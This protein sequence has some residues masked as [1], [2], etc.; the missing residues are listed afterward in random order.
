MFYLRR[1]NS[2]NKLTDWKPFTTVPSNRTYRR[3]VQIKLTKA[4]VVQEE[5]SPHWDHSLPVHTPF[6]FQCDTPVQPRPI[7]VSQLRTR[8]T[9]PVSG[10]AIQNSGVARGCENHLSHEPIR[11][12]WCSLRRRH[13]LQLLWNLKFHYEIPTRFTHG[14]KYDMRTL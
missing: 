9:L 6:W 12:S 2:S 7:S 3:Q 14:S 4:N 5:K 8:A 10:Y 13:I 1:Q 11:R